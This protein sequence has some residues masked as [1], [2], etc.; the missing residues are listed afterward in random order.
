MGAGEE[1]Y[2]RLVSLI[3][4]WAWSHHRSTGPAVGKVSWMTCGGK[5]E[6]TETH[7]GK[8][9]SIPVSLSPTTWQRWPAEGA[10]ALLM[11]LQPLGSDLRVTEGGDALAAEEALILAVAPCQ[12]GKLRARCKCLV[13]T[14]SMWQLLL[15]F[16]LTNLLKTPLLANSNLQPYRKA[17]LEV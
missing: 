1:V 5:Q 7:E 4:W 6:Q 15:H 9:R 16:C 3:Q 2:G 17:C 13:L 8:L 11:E 12:E 14:F 10:S